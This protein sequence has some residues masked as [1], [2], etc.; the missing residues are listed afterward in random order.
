MY[1][2][3]PEE[4]FRNV[5]FCFFEIII[6]M[7]KNNKMFRAKKVVIPT[8]SWKARR[9]K[10]GGKYFS[11]RAWFRTYF[12]NGDKV[13][14]QFIQQKKLPATLHRSVI[15]KLRLKSRVKIFIRITTIHKSSSYGLIICCSTQPW[16]KRSTT[17]SAAS[18][19]S[20]PASRPS[21][22]RPPT[23][24]F[25]RVILGH[26]PHICRIDLSTSVNCVAVVLGFCR[27]SLT[28]AP[29]WRVLFRLV[30][31]ISPHFFHF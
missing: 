23:R 1:I 27:H 7:Q 13:V 18:P 11:L 6:F 8:N 19:A 31:Y 22:P 26:C 20:S 29:L 28:F 4:A 30:L 15:A 12:G 5:L 10:G 14:L 16:R 2:I 3:R 25:H 17:P 9:W 24:R 21:C